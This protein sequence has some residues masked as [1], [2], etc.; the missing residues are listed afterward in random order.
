MSLMNTTVQTTRRSLIQAGMIGSLGLDVATLN[1]LLAAESKAGRP[2]ARAKSVLFIF[3]SGGL[4][5]LDSFDMKPEGPSAYRGEFQPVDTSAEGIQICEHLPH[6]AKRMHHL[7]LVRSMTHWCNEHNESH[8]LMLTGRS[9]LPP[10]YQVNKPQSSDWPSIVAT[11]GQLVASRSASLPSSMVVPQRLVNMNQSGVVIPGQFAGQMG[12]RS[13]PW[14][15]EASPYRGGDVKGAYPDF[16]FRR[17]IEAKVVDKSRFQAPVLSLPEGLTGSRLSRRSEMLVELDRQRKGLQVHSGTKR[18]QKF[19]DAAVSLLTD[20]KVRHAFDVVNADEAT[21][22]RYGR[23]LFGW[24]LLMARRL[25]EAGVPLVQANLGN[26]NTWDLHGG[27]FPLSRDLLYP[28][29][30]QA[31]AALLD[32]LSESGLLDET[33]VVIAS[34]FGRTPRIFTLPRVFKSPGRDHWGALQTVLFAGAGVQGGTV[35]GSSDRSGAYPDSLPQT[36]E[37]FAATIY[38][39]LGLPRDAAWSDVDGRPNF[40]YHDSPIVGVV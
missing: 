17:R 20:P 26:F 35:V 28:P 29:A 13:D 24:T 40:I 7:A 31:I 12:S 1:Q 19:Q 30:D 34:E 11:A 38:D 15:V 22:R 4:S 10:G 5:Q 32:D 6:L 39:A 8:T 36:P 33:L 37:N 21:S 23:N 3:L 27:I 9:K 2:A 18:L 14:F 16:A 25:V